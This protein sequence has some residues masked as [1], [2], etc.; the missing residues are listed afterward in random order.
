VLTG[1]VIR[2][3]GGYVCPSANGAVIGATMEPGRSDSVVEPAMA[4]MLLETAVQAVPR[5]RGA[6]TVGRAGVRAATPDGLP[7]VGPSLTPGVWIAAG[8]RRNGWLLAPL[9]AEALVATLA[10]ERAPEAFSPARLPRG[11]T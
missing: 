3:G 1:P 4:A 5:L 9:I 2:Y 10:G 8:A 7:L 6:R 11:R